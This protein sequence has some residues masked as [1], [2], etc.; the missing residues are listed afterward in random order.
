[1]P[2]LKFVRDL[3]T[4]NHLICFRIFIPPGVY[5]GM[6]CFPANFLSFKSFLLQKIFGCYDSLI[7]RQEL[8]QLVLL[9][10]S[11]TRLAFI[12][13]IITLGTTMKYFEIHSL[14]CLKS[15]FSRNIAFSLALFFLYVGTKKG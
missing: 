15:Q 5:S 11:G 4:V 6:V 9:K 7:C 2:A 13:L 10:I 12:Y 14:I 1:M 3:V 8:N